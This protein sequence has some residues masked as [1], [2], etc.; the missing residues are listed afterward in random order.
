VLLTA[1]GSPFSGSLSGAVEIPGDE[2][3]IF[4][5]EQAG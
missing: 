5:V 3:V 1:S 4:E 2:A